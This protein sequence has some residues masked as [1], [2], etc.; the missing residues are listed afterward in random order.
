MQHIELST[1]NFLHL[2]QSEK[3]VSEKSIYVYYAITSGEHLDAF[4]IA[5]FAC[6]RTGSHNVSRVW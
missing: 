2:M 5:Y 1:E 6:V 4:A 3:I